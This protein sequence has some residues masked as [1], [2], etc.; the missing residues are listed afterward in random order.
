MIIGGEIME[1]CKPLINTSL[2][3]TDYYDWLLKISTSINK[4]LM[5]LI[6]CCILLK[7]NLV[8]ILIPKENSCLL[9]L[10][11]S[12]SLSLSVS[13]GLWV[14]LGLLFRGHYFGELAQVVALLCNALVFS[15]VLVFVRIHRQVSEQDLLLQCVHLKRVILNQAIITWET[16]FVSLPGG[17]FLVLSMWFTWIVPCF[18]KF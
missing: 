18:F 7:L 9:S 13:F 1:T 4:E 3:H 6:S 2:K 14:F 11:A 15:L 5:H 12:L 8:V 10:S 16:L 17:G